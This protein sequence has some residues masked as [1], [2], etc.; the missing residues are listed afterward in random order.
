MQMVSAYTGAE[1]HR[2]HGDCRTLI[3]AGL[4]Q[5][6]IIRQG[7]SLAHS[8]IVCT[9]TG[10]RSRGDVVVRCRRSVR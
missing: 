5:M 7:L 2:L 4:G 1:P 8:Q 3:H 9:G 6:V 10:S